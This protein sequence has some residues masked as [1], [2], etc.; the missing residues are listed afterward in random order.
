MG[1]GEA[2]P[3]VVVVDPPVGS[4]GLSDGRCG[5]SAGSPGIFKDVP[6]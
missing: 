6:P 2:A 5:A 3:R 4:T 1:D